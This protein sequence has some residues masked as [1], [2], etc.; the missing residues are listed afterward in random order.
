M[1]TEVKQ[2]NNRIIMVVL[3]LVL[4][5]AAFGLS[6]YVSKSGSNGTGTA[7]SARTS[8]APR[9]GCG[10]VLHRS[11]PAKANTASTYHASSGIPSMENSGS[12]WRCHQST[13]THA[14]KQETLKTMMAIKG[15]PRG[16]TSADF[17]HHNR[18]SI[19]NQEPCGVSPVVGAPGVSPSIIG[20]VLGRPASEHA[21]DGYFAST[22]FLRL[23]KPALNTPSIVSVAVLSF[24]LSGGVSLKFLRLNLADQVTNVLSAPSDVTTK[25]AE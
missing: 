5:A 19:L 4:A 8:I 9:A 21:S 16:C 11:S 3:G 17:R 7:P 18:N 2:R 1:A 14:L 15:L 20:H 6:L 13:A 24:S 22:I 12:G 10:R 25:V 23:S